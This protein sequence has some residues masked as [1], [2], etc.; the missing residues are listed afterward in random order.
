MATST[1]TSIGAS[2]SNVSST[3]AS[4]AISGLA[5][6]MNW[7]SIVQE[8]G[9]A[10]RT[11]EIQWRNQQATIAAQN[12]AYS[13]LT[14]DLTTLQTD[15]QN[16]LIP[17]FFDTVVATSS[18]P[19]VA[20]A[21]VASGTPI[22]NYAF[23]ITQLATAAQINGTANVSQVLDPSGDPSKVT[24]GAAGFS[25]PVTPGTITVNGQQITIATTDSLK[26]VF[27]NIA[28]A[29]LAAGNKVTASYSAVTD[30]ITL[31]SGNGSPIVLGSSTDTSNFLQDAQ[32]YNNNSGT[33]SSTAAL[34][35]VNPFATLNAADLKTPISDGGSGQGKFTINGVSFSFNASTDSLQDILNNINHSAAGVSASY[36]PVNNRFVLANKTTGDVGIA[37]QDVTGNFLAATGLS[38]GT[39]SHGKNLLYNLNGSAQQLVS[40]SNTIGSASSGII[41]L[42]VTALALGTTTVNVSSD[43]ATIS[44]AIQKFV[45]DYNAAQ[46]FITSQQ[47]VTTAAD[48]S[49]TPGTLTGDTNTND[50]ANTL[51]ALAGAVQS[52][53]GTSGKVNSLG[54]LGF[55]SNGNDNT[56]A[57]SDSSSLTSLLTTNLNDIKALFSDATKGLG[58]QM[59]K[60][61]TNTTGANGTLTVRQDDL[62]KQSSNIGTQISNLETK[63]NNDMNQW[64]SE[65]AAMETAQS[66][67]NAELT[68]ISQG[69]TNGSL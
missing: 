43:T 22:G 56:M 53:A 25:T 33:I 49:V 65:F 30:K 48:G 54:D 20:T 46:S 15:A 55:K 27:D 31:T 58:V 41:G 34:G 69:V 9:N 57:L 50:I 61:T 21:S 37:L 13:T 60:Y 14:N 4:M 29:T 26:T 38:G 35:H 5:S 28:A 7:T 17:S 16:L 36:D 67:T 47:A 44:T 66:Q 45:T 1:V 63:I 42:S 32:L 19:A 39:L 23:N 18:T 2:T 62:V 40:Q 68:Y 8:L 24:V 6:G 11:P 52:I 3:A 12:S 59:A 51:R 10:E 64:N